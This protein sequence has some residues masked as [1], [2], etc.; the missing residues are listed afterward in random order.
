MRRTTS[1]WFPYA[2]GHGPLVNLRPIPARVGLELEQRMTDRGLVP[3]QDR[4]EVAIAL[5]HLSKVID[6]V[7]Y[8]EDVPVSRALLRLP[9]DYLTSMNSPRRRLA[10][11]AGVVV[12]WIQ[13]AA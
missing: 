7:I 2:P 1:R 6:A 11:S 10:Y 13:S 3:E 5:D 9:Q 12:L 8:A 4:S